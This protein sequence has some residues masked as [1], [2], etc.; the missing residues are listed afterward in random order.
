MRTPREVD[1]FQLLQRVLRALEM[2]GASDAQVLV[3]HGAF[4]WKLFIHTPGVGSHYDA[5]Y[6]NT[7]HG[8]ITVAADTFRDHGF[9][10]D[11]A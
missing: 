8:S 3:R 5:G 11:Q 4:E 9:L 1:Q 2:I 10:A 6:I 7:D